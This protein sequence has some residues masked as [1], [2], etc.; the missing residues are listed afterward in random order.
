MDIREQII[1]NG[2]IPVKLHPYTELRHEKLQEVESDIDAF[3]KE[4]AD[5]A[6][7]DMDRE[8]KAEFWMRKA[9]ILWEPVIDKDEKGNP[10]NIDPEHWDKDEKFF[11]K[12]F[13][14]DKAFEYTL[15]RKSQDFFLMQEVFL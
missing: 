10:L 7:R 6:F 12:A 4:N 13:F 14:E 2:S 3:A 9:E 8:K 5:L 11:S 1:V 15:I